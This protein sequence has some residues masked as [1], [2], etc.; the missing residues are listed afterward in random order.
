M[1]VSEEHRGIIEVLTEHG[2]EFA[3]THDGLAAPDEQTRRIIKGCVGMAFE[4]GVAYGT[5]SRDMSAEDR[6]HAAFDIIRK[7]KVL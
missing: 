4:F 3:G 1:I 6:M 7:G 5:T 2:I